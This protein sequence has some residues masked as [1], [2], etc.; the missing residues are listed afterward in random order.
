[1]DKKASATT[2]EDIEEYEIHKNKRKEEIKESKKDE[3]KIRHINTT[4][5]KIMRIIR[6]KSNKKRRK[7][8]Y[9]INKKKEKQARSRN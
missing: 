6:S 1:M 7:E 3:I 8:E 5:K 4:R 2:K 9:M